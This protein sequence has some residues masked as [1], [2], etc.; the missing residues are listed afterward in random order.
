MTACSSGLAWLTMAVVCGSAS[1]GGK[2]VV[3]A[4]ESAGGGGGDSTAASSASGA[5]GQGGGPATNTGSGASIPPLFCA[6]DKIGFSGTI[7]GVVLLDTVRASVDFADVVFV[8]AIADDGGIFIAPQDISMES[9]L[10]LVRIPS[11]PQDLSSPVP[12][13]PGQWLC[14]LDAPFTATVFGSPELL[15]GPVTYSH[16]RR[17]GTC[18]GTPI[19]GEIVCQG[20][21]CDL[22]EIGGT[23][24]GVSP[25]PT[26]MSFFDQGLFVSVLGD[27]GALLLPTTHPDAQALYCA[28]TVVMS[29]AGVLTIGELS[30]LGRCDEGTSVSGTVTVCGGFPA[31]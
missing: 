22:G 24:T 8:G 21:S 26:E 5:G 10:G 23:I 25:D 14:D 28:G 18:P 4:M 19:G 29:D 11:P 30:R 27:G 16:L 1:C 15:A 6:A 20:S 12:S 2:V 3:D 17:L 31:P 9:H 13:N 7:D